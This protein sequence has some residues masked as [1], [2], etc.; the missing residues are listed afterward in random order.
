MNPRRKN[1]PMNVLLNGR[2][3]GNLRM[4]RDGAISFAYAPDWLAWDYAVPVSL[5][6]P[7]REQA[8]LGESVVA[9]LE[10]LLP[11]SHEFRYRIAAKLQAKG[12]GA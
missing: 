8:H 5:S 7:L 1:P 2:L 12:T 4:G 10:N 6:L 9:Y 3:V 11:E